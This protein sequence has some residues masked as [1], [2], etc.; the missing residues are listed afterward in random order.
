VQ[1]LAQLKNGGQAQKMADRWVLPMSD[2]ARGKIILGDMTILFQFVI[3]P[4]LQPRPQLPQSVRGRL[5]DRIDPMPL[6][7]WLRRWRSTPGDNLARGSVSIA[8]ATARSSASTTRCLPRSGGVD[9]A[10]EPKISDEGTK[11][12]EA[13]KE[14]A[15]GDDAGAGGGK[16]DRGRQAGGVPGGARGADGLEVEKMA[17][18]KAR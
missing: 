15:K 3:A 5:L 2:A 12:A 16:P 1:A 17:E 11:P 14:P 10:Q 4:P 18:G 9:G 13:A 7:P 6:S 8:R